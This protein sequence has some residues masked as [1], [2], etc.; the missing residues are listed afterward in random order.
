M[1]T[2]NYTVV[3]NNEI[4]LFIFKVYLHYITI[5]FKN[6]KYNSIEYILTPY[7]SLYVQHMCDLNQI[8]YRIRNF[9]SIIFTDTLIVIHYI[10][11]I[12]L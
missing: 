5:F 7:I 9:Q 11:Q 6:A 1:K 8:S 4:Y 10:L 12:L 2:K 3:L